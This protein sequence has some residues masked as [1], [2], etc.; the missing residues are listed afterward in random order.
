MTPTELPRLLFGPDDADAFTLFQ[1][2]EA[3]RFQRKLRHADDSRPMGMRLSNPCPCCRVKAVFDP[4]YSLPIDEGVGDR[5]H[6]MESRVRACL[7]RD[8]DH[9]AQVPIEWGD[10][11]KSAWDFMVGN[12]IPTWSIADADAILEVKSA[13]NGTA[14]TATHKAQVTRMAAADDRADHC[15]VDFLIVSPSSY[16]CWHTGYY[17]TED[18]LAP[19]R[20]ELEACIKAHDYLDQLDDPTTSTEWDSDEWWQELGVAQC[21]KCKQITTVDGDNA[22]ERAAWRLDLTSAALREAKAAYDT[23]RTAAAERFDAMRERKELPAD[24]RVETWMP[25]MRFYRDSRGVFR[26]DPVKDK[27][28]EDAA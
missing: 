1:Q 4:W 2:Y 17:I 27:Q 21:S 8:T 3:E 7:L 28:Q 23:A 24:A 9:E 15:L 13:I 14:P 11:N 26:C 10:G 22:M 16:Q 20:A 19:A 25:R 5:G 18:E 12:H 6:E